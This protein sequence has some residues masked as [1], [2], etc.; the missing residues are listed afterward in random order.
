MFNSARVPYIP[1]QTLA[2]RFNAHFMLKCVDVAFILVMRILS[3]R[4]CYFL[5]VLCWGHNFFSLSLELA[6]FLLLLPCVILCRSEIYVCVCVCVCVHICTYMLE[7]G[8]YKEAG[9]RSGS[10]ATENGIGR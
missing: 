8:E 10:V 3:C 5:D 4:D 2:R 1:L 7:M 9:I 6:K